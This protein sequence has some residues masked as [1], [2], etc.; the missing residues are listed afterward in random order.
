MAICKL[1]FWGDTEINLAIYQH[2]NDEFQ[3]RGALGCTRVV[4]DRSG[5]QGL[6]IRSPSSRRASSTSAALSH[7]VTA[8]SHPVT[9]VKKFFVASLLVY[10]P[11]NSTSFAALNT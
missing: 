11:V 5:R 2:T 6:S 1:E 9:T 10:L 7:P 4:N 8:A 3:Y